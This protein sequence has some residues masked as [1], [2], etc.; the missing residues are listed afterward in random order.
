MAGVDAFLSRQEV[1]L[2]F[3]EV[4]DCAFSWIFCYKISENPTDA[5]E[6]ELAGDL[7]NNLFF[8]VF[9]QAECISS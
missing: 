2:S 1:T 4:S 6:A 8:R 7:L 3:A 9:K 5:F